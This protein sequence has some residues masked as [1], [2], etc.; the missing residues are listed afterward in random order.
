MP[1]EETL[2]NEQMRELADEQHTPERTLWFARIIDEIL[3]TP[4]RTEISGDAERNV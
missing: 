4:V 1:N 2:S 3:C